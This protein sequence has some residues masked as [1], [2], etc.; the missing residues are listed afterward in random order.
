MHVLQYIRISDWPRESKVNCVI[1]VLKGVLEP[2]GIVVED[3][4][5]LGL[6][7]LLG[8]RLVDMLG[9]GSRLSLRRSVDVDHG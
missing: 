4:T 5:A 7:S 2:Q 1:V 6:L 3:S 8:S 9:A